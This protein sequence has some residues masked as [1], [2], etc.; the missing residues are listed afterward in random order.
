MCLVYTD[1][2]IGKHL[3]C[4]WIRVNDLVTFQK[5]LQNLNAS[6]LVLES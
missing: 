5:Q 2:I 6:F 3:E 1:F 4:I